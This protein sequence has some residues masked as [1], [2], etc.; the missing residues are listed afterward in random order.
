MAT[1]NKDLAQPVVNSTNWDVPLNANTGVI[2]AALGGNT[3]KNVT[4]VGTTPVVL[5][6]SEYQKL[7]L[8]F[9]GTL[10]ANVIYHIPSGVGGQWIVRNAASGAFTLTIGNVA[11]GTSVEIPQSSQRTVYSD[12][13]NIRF[14]DDQT[15][16]PAF[17][18]IPTAPTAS[19]G[20]NTTQIATTAF[21]NAEIANDAP[22]KTG[23]GAS[24]TW[25]ISITGTAAGSPGQVSTFAM[26]TAPSGWLKANGAAVSRTTYATLFAAIGTTFGVGDGST[27]FNLPDL[28]G[29]FMRGWD[30]GRGVD[31]GR[32]F[33]SAQ[34]DQMQRLTGTLQTNIS[35]YGGSVA[36]SGMVQGNGG[37]AA[38]RVGGS[39]PSSST[40]YNIDSATSPNARVSSTTSGETRARNIALLAC[41]KF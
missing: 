11:A 32:A 17:T 35:A 10:T 15:V 41:I 4:G 2:D 3:T 30:D 40:L 7:I 31:S 21:V 20:T 39:S 23:T 12:G 28:R 9:S 19:V 37:N 36:A 26:N 16:S 8:T 5:T 27:T 38:N 24:G 34:L 6:T 33:G 14:S 13:T 29:E 25:N 18:G 1:T 22:S